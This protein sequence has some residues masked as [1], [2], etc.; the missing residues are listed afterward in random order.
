MRRRSNITSNSSAPNPKR[1]RFTSKEYQSLSRKA[2]IF[3]KRASV[4][5]R[6]N[7]GR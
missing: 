6:R 1:R 3:G 5:R 4:L 2:E 7:N